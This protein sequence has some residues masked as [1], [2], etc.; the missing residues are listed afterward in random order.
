MK[1]IF[2]C[3]AGIIGL[4]LLTTARAN[5]FAQHEQAHS[6]GEHESHGQHHVGLFFDAT[7]NFEED[8]T[9]FL[10]ALIKKLLPRL[11]IG[12]LG[13]VTFAEEEVF[14]VGAPIFLHPTDRLVLGVAPELE[15]V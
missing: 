5:C 14:I 6:E 8:E 13:E 1:Y 10:L 7:T 4:L 15:I 9:D 12:F 2:G 3:R 11:G